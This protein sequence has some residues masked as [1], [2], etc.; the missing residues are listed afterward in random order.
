VQWTQGRSLAATAMELELEL[1]LGRGIWRRRCCPL[2]PQ[3]L[4][5]RWRMRPAPR[6][7]TPCS[8]SAPFSA[9]SLPSAPCSAWSSTSSPSCAPSTTAASTTA[10][11]YVDTPPSLLHPHSLHCSK[12][13][14]LHP[15]LQFL[16]P[17]FVA[18]LTKVNVNGCQEVTFW[19][20][21]GHFLATF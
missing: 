20:L 15:L 4:L 11:V 16:V 10:S 19:P 5:P 13:I 7:P 18:L 8:T 2:R 9:S 1:E 14:I 12:Q 6:R 3:A 21:F 17:V